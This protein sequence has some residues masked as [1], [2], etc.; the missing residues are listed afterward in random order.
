M[1]KLGKIFGPLVAILAI[2]AA[3][4]SFLIANQRQMFRN[5]A[6]TL[7]NTVATMVDNLDADNSSGVKKAVTF[8]SASETAPKEGGT[9]GWEA[10]KTSEKMADN[11]YKGTVGKA[12]KL[13]NDVNKQRNEL[14][15]A[16]NNFVVG[17]G[18]PPNVLNLSN[19]ETYQKNLP[20]L[21]QFLQ[22]LL[23]RDKLVLENIN[24]IGSIVHS[25]V[26]RSYM[27]CKYDDVNKTLS[28]YSVAPAFSSFKKEVQEVKTREQE[29][30]KGVSNSIEAINEYK[31]WGVSST[32]LRNSS[33]QQLRAYMER[34]VADCRKIGA[35]LAEMKVWKADLERMKSEKKQIEERFAA[36][37]TKNVEAEKKIAE[38]KKKYGVDMME[39]NNTDVLKTMPALEDIQGVSLKTSGKILQ[40]NKKLSFVMLNLNNKQVIKGLNLAVVRNGAYIATIV[41]YETT[42]NFAMANIHSGDINNLAAGD[43]VILSALDIAKI[44]KMQEN[45]GQQHEEED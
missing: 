19:L 35:K 8:T 2:A 39:V 33:A 7:S 17:L 5:R 30:V 12:T 43:D 9:L 21:D 20:K 37:E 45:V 11:S 38:L 13:S 4:L 34:Y 27:T 6:S 18:Y 3:V 22:A 40:V 26:S 32:E 31:D 29:F 24:E 42:D 10:Y 16:I 14:S 25:S 36:L 44:K 28:D 23:I 41:I 15:V 1:D